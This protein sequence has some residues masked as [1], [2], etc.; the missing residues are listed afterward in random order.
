MYEIS[1]SVSSAQGASNKSSVALAVLECE[2]GSSICDCSELLSC[3]SDGMSLNRKECEH[4]C[5]N[6]MCA[7]IVMMN[8]S[9]NESGIAEAGGTENLMLW[10]AAGTIIVV[11]AVAVLLLLR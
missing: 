11:V 1:V 10:V 7:E 9:S 2:P 3:S 6:S 4:G 5:I 8:T